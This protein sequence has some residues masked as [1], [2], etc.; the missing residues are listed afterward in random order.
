MH[1]RLLYMVIEPGGVV[2]SCIGYGYQIDA[3]GLQSHHESNSYSDVRTGMPVVGSSSTQE[4]KGTSTA[5][6]G[7]LP[8][9]DRTA[10]LALEKSAAVAAKAPLVGAAAPT[11][12]KNTVA[13]KA[14]TNG[15]H[16]DHGQLTF[17]LS[18]CLCCP[19]CPYAYN[20]S[21]PNP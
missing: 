13:E 19:T 9:A 3:F 15:N 20:Y 8:A 14:P 5:V 18:I 21:C 7:F 4:K 10:A 6:V 16:L 1:T 17:F 12:E 2:V 11:A